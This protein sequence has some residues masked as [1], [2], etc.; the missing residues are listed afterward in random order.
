MK[1]KQT[2]LIIATTIGIGG[3]V[4]APIAS[5]ATCGG[6]TT[7]I[8]SCPQG[9]TS[10]PQDNGVWG[11]LIVIINILSAGVG[12]AAVGGVVIGSFMYM[13]AGGSPERTKKANLFLTNVILGIIVYAAMWAFLNFLIPGGLF[14]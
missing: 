6:V 8:I 14:T 7:S 4:F 2:V 3:F 5:A 11:L 1:I 13:T 10:N 12:I 9:G